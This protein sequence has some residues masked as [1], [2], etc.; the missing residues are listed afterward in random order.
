MVPSKTCCVAHTVDIHQIQRQHSKTMVSK[1]T[2]AL[3]V[4]RNRVKQRQRTWA[5]EDK[6]RS[7]GR[8]KNSSKKGQQLD[9]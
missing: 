1:E 7:A 2:L 6:D 3:K 8:R 5:D 4:A 9:S